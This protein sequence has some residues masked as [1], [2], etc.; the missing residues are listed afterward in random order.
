MSR[1]AASATT[2]ANEAPG[3]MLRSL[4][5]EQLLLTN[6]EMRCSKIVK[7]NV[8]RRRLFARAGIMHGST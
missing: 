5:A 8:S 2:T 1:M 6:E 7:D 3:Q 4:L